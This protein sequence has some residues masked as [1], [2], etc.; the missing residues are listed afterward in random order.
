MSG[1]PMPSWVSDAR[2]EYEE[3]ISTVPGVAKLRHE[4]KNMIED[5]STL[6][7]EY[8][9]KEKDILVHLYP[10][11]DA[12]D[13]WSEGHFINRCRNCRTERDLSKVKSMT[14]LTACPKCDH[15]G[16]VYVPGRRDELGEKVM[17]PVDM[18]DRIAQAAEDT[19]MGE[20]AA[21]RAV[22]LR[23]ASEQE[24]ENLEE[25]QP[26]DTGAYTVQF[27]GAKGTAATIGLRKFV[28]TFCEHLDAQLGG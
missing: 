21:E 19:W 25:A 22:L 1:M 13:L 9:E 15:L 26:V 11:I 8:E 23:Y 24:I 28:D 17:F 27:Q 7:A 5:F 14:D 18:L 4:V 16:L 10:R 20:T 2:G 12:S 6:F 3:M